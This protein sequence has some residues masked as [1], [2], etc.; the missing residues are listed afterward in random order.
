MAPT[1]LLMGIFFRAQKMQRN[2]RLIA[3]APTVVSRPDIKE[4]AR[5][6]DVS[7]SIRHRTR[8]FPGYHHANVLHLTKRTPGNR[9][10]VLRPFAPRYTSECLAWIKTHLNQRTQT[11]L[12]TPL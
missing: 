9:R 6:H 5:L 1:L 8:G 7:S 3:N 4:I 12:A 11:A 10:D 2:I